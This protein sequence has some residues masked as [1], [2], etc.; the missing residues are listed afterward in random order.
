MHK[1]SSFFPYFF[2]FLFLSFLLVFSS[3]ISFLKPINSFGQAIFAPVQSLTHGIFSAVVNIGASSKVKLLEEENRA[4]A[5]K[6]VDLKKIESDN[7]ALKDQFQTIN[8]RSTSLLPAQ[9]IGEQGFLPGISIPETL[10]LN[11][12]K[13][14][15]IKVG[16]AVVY[17]DNLIGKVISVSDFLSSVS[18]ITNSNSTFTASSLETNAQGV[19]KGEDGGLIFDNILLSENLKKDDLIITKGD[20]NQKGEGFLPGLIVGKISSI[21]KN[22]S[23]LFQKAKVKQLVD[24]TKLNMVFVII[25]P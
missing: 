18:L 20:L 13:T 7:K 24:L 12:G 2:L 10:I 14:D 5:K 21:S 17:K 9:I 22:A 1:R 19:I 4:L 11:R 3:K 25:N 6:L 15:G 8:I 16:Q 23:D